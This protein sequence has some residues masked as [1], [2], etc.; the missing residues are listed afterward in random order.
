MVGSQ[1]FRWFVEKYGFNNVF[2]HSLDRMD[3][4]AYHA[5]CIFI[6]VPTPFDW[7]KHQ[8]NGDI[9]REAVRLCQAGSTIVVKSTVKIGTTEELQREFPQKKIIFNPEFLSEKTAWADFIN[10]D[11]QFVGYTEKSYDV[12]TQVLD[13]LPLSPAGLVMPSKQAE[14]LKYINNLHGI[15]EVL[16]S[17]HY[18][19][20][21]QKE[22]LD[23]EATINAAIKSKWV[24]VPMGRHYRT[25]HHKGYRGV[26]GACFPKD[27]S[28]WLEYCEESGINY[29]IFAAAW[30][31]NDRI[32]EEQ[33]LKV[34]E[35]EK[36]R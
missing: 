4:R 32:L 34:E 14:L 21:C 27:L 33:G 10:P 7:K 6:C 1:V 23:Y 19:E 8:Y 12:S 15:L 13:V 29:E 20:V 31:M 36:I 11:R 28:A 25:I 3:V 30:R 26:G 5:D 22:G 16:E 24:G 18:Y 35:V 17:N 2:G 9:V